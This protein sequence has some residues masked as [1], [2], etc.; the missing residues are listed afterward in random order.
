M[1]RSGGGLTTRARHNHGMTISPAH[2]ITEAGPVEPTLDHLVYATPDL[3][4]AVAQFEA[5]TGVRPAAGGRHLGRGTRNHLVR[6]GPRSYLEII[7]PDVEHPAASGAGLP[8]GIDELDGPRLLT[9]AVRPGD[10]D[11]AV[12]RSAAAGADLGPALPMSRRT[13]VGDLLEWRLASAVP[14]PFGGVT[15]FLIDWGASV[16]P[17]SDATMP[18]VT[19]DALSA[20]HPDPAGVRGVLDA[21]GLVLSVDRGPAGLRAVLGTRNG[22]VVLS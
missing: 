14:V 20:T 19:L 11:S 8:F 6:L 13:P 4:A 15:P 3:A 1:D 17:S 12:A 10:L 2:S 7:G 16:H 5:A 18:T 9:W 21:L 22:P